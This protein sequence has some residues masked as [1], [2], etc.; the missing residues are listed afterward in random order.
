MNVS[1]ILD[2]KIWVLC[3]SSVSTRLSR[4]YPALPLVSVWIHLP[5][6]WQLINGQWYRKFQSAPHRHQAFGRK[7]T[8]FHFIM[9]DVS[10]CLAKVDLRITAAFSLIHPSC[11]S[12]VIN[13]FYICSKWFIRPSFIHNNIPNGHNP[14]N[15][16]LTSS[17]VHLNVI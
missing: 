15:S 13:M 8:F 9:K 5:S 7:M 10:L 11:W 6:P 14:S 3:A 2:G 12:R 1:V 16:I 4:R 17:N